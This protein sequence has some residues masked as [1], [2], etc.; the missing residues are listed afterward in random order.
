MDFGEV[1]QP[2]CATEQ[3]ERSRNVVD[4]VWTKLF[5]VGFSRHKKF[6]T[7]MSGAS[8]ARIYKI[9][10]LMVLYTYAVNHLRITLLR[11]VHCSI[12]A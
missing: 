5:L 6:L 1:S 10:S 9:G 11:T 3:G 7:G 4:S 8:P 2:V 12:G